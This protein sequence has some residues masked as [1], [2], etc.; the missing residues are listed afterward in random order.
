MMFKHIKK[1]LSRNQGRKTNYYEKTTYSECRILSTLEPYI[2]P[3]C[4][5]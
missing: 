2:D 1:G 4:N 5:G 3:S